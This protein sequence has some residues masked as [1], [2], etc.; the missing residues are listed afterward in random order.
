MNIFRCTNT[1]YT[2]LLSVFNECFGHGSDGE[3]FQSHMTHCTPSSD[4]AD[5]EEIGNHL[6]CAID[7]RIVGGLG[8]YPFE[9]K[10]DTGEGS[11]LI[12]AYKIGQVS[13]LK[14]YRGRGVMTALMEEAAHNMKEQGCTLGYLNG[15]IE[16][17]RH[18]GYTYGGLTMAF[19][20]SRKLVLEHSKDIEIST[21]QITEPS[22]ISKAYDA[23]PSR[24]TRDEKYWQR[25]FEREHITWHIGESK[26]G[27]GYLAIM[28]RNNICELYGNEN[29]LVAM[30]SEILNQNPT[31]EVVAKYPYMSNKEQAIGQMLRD[32][33]YGMTMHPLGLMCGE[34]ETVAAGFWVSEVDN[35]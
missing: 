10:V 22:E 21:K 16:R 11:L 5:A 34:V 17:Y 32:I 23:L 30:L 4:I 25:Q 27:K 9:W 15:D 26:H 13:C 24:A 6:A 18:F 31:T 8:V 20:L 12:P 3:W 35:A 28:N 1:D 19:N 14:E 2:K 7:G 29:T 33:S